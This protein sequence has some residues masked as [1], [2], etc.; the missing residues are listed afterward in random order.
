MPHAGREGRQ[1]DEDGD[2]CRHQPAPSGGPQ[3]DQDPSH[4]RGPGQAGVGQRQGETDRSHG[5]HR[6]DPRLART[7][8]DVRHEDQQHDREEVAERV[9][10]GEGRHDALDPVLDLDAVQPGQRADEGHGHGHHRG[11]E[12]G[13]DE[14]IGAPG[15][16]AQPVD[17]EEHQNR[18]HH[19]GQLT[20]AA[21]RCITTER[22]DGYG[23]QEPGGRHPGYRARM[24]MPGQA[25][26][27]PP[28]PAHD[29]EQRSQH[30]SGI[31]DLGPAWRVQAVQRRPKYQHYQD[32]QLH[33]APGDEHQRRGAGQAPCRERPGRAGSTDTREHQQTGHRRQQDHDDLWQRGRARFRLGPGRSSG[34]RMSRHRAILPPSVVNRTAR[35]AGRGPPGQGLLRT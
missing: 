33:A 4:G 14:A 7:E 10:L 3:H 11:S 18:G 15:G 29:D 27:D 23:G 9:R 19:S 12:H 2:Q 8:Q 20:H 6:Q 22:G 21:A 13:D 35:P 26:P 31:R 30:L 34:I 17:D 5:D 32:K 1:R 28:H 24:A 25:T 16:L